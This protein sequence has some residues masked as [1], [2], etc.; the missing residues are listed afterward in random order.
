[1]CQV[2]YFLPGLFAHVHRVS[3]IQV[4]PDGDPGEWCVYLRLIIVF[5]READSLHPIVFG[6]VVAP[7]SYCKSSILGLV[8]PGADFATIFGLA[9][10]E[11]FIDTRSS[12]RQAITSNSTVK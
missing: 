11:H 5:H 4:P 7:N 8:A 12:L 1:M 9:G 10:G 3:S 2:A 6:A